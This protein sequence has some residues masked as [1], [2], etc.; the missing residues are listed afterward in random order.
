MVSSAG[1]D[2]RA[3]PAG[4]SVVAGPAEAVAERLAGLLGPRFNPL[5]LMLTGADPRE[6]D[7]QAMSLA[8]EVLPAMRQAA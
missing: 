5:N 7:E 1:V 3:D 4:P 2:K 8:Q 6:N